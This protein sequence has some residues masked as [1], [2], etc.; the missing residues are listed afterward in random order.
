MAA[1]AS[2]QRVG[3]RLCEIRSGASA[4]YECAAGPFAEQMVAPASA[5]PTRPRLEQAVPRRGM[6]L[7][8]VV[9][10]GGCRW[11][12]RRGLCLTS[13]GS[14]LSA[15]AEGGATVSLSG[16]EAAVGSAGVAGDLVRVAHGDVVDASTARAGFR[17]GRDLLA[18]V[19]RV[20]EG[21]CLGAAARAAARPLTCGR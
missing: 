3:T 7:A 19:G 1:A 4:E 9:K 8:S 6:P 13:C 16:P 20:A 17:F 2:K 15:V 12:S 11:L 21:R 10:L 18:A 14:W 5:A